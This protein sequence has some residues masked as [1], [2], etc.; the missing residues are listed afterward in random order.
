MG[1]CGWITSFLKN[2]RIIPPLFIRAYSSVRLER[3]PDKGEVDGSNPSRPIK[4]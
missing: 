1:T 3:T 2:S 4:N